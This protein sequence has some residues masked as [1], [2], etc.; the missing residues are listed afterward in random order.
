MT[1]GTILAIVLKSNFVLLMFDNIIYPA[2]LQ[3]VVLRVELKEQK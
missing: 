3:F 2:I 1:F